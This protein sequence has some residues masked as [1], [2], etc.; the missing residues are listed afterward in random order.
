MNDQ[1]EIDRLMDII[2]RAQVAFFEHGSDQL[3]AIRMMDI[4]EEV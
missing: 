3:A 1:D 4:L 2:K